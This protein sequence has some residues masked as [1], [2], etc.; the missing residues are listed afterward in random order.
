MFCFK[1]QEPRE[2]PSRA[3]LQRQYKEAADE[4][5]NEIRRVRYGNFWP[6][7][8][9]ILLRSATNRYERRMDELSKYK[10]T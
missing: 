3:W 7:K 6:P 2:P 8:P 5:Y 10:W 4:Y 9:W 1:P